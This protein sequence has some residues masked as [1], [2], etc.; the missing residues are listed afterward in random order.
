MGCIPLGYLGW[1]KESTPREISR[2]WFTSAHLNS[3]PVPSFPHTHG[4][5]QQENIP[6]QQEPD[7]Y[8]LKLLK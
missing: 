7:Q 5:E 6:I 4:E 3:A 1:G 2:M 8:L